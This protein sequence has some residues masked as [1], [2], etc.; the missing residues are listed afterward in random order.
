MHI[1]S[2]TH[3][4][5]IYE[6]HML[7]NDKQNREI[8]LVNLNGSLLFTSHICWIELNLLESCDHTIKTNRF[9]SVNHRK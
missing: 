8:S 7:T 9:C 6:F 1:T 5:Q 4:F 3:K 2:M